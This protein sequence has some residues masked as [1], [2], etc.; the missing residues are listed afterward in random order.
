MRKFIPALEALQEPLP[1][2]ISLEDELM[3]VDDCAR[4]EAQVAADV[5]EVNKALDL[6]EA[7]E[8]LA[9]VAG[10]LTEPTSGEKQ[11]ADMC[12]QMATAGSDVTPEE[13]LP[14]VES[15]AEGQTISVEGYKERAKEIWDSIQKYLAHIW[16][17]IVAFF[18]GLFKQVPMYK[19]RLAALKK[20]LEGLK[21]GHA[22]LKEKSEV[23]A[24]GSVGH[25]P[26]I[27]G[28][29]YVHA[30]DYFSKIASWVFSDY[31]KYVLSAGEKTVVAIKNFSAEDPSRAASELRYALAALKIPKL[32]GLRSARDNGKFKTESS[33]D[34]LHNKVLIVADYQAADGATT[35]GVLEK[36][37]T[38][39]VQLA[40]ARGG[41]EL[42]S[43]EH[44]GVKPLTLEQMLA[45]VKEF[46]DQLDQVDKFQ[47]SK[48]EGDI[49]RVKKELAEASAA[50][51]K[52]FS[53]LDKKDESGHFTTVETFYRATLNFNAAFLQWVQQ[54]L[55]TFSSLALSNVRSGIARI[56]ESLKCYV[57]DEVAD[58]H[59]AFRHAMDTPSL[60]H[61]A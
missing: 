21:R 3:L 61:P 29:E 57:G 22:T 4:H 35:L 52:T 40:D 11:L 32:P 58:M 1:V 31:A 12:S 36:L 13:F 5:T 19:K 41:H 30:N 54:P 23:T 8:D 53:G 37:R 49:A 34:L 24:F 38:S 9:I 28:A 55:L 26:V 7:L 60:P 45:L 51:A 10:K 39:H 25:K 18:K 59:P 48:S 47:S 42:A 14:A 17:H 2:S 56:G 33:E 27:E 44:K 43:H 6:S 20:T 16:N 15:L 46:E 50:A